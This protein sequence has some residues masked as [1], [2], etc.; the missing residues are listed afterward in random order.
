MQTRFTKIFN[1]RYPIMLGGMVWLGRSQLAAAVS[2]AG[3][4]GTIN[5]SNFRTGDAL[6]QEIRATK[7]L[8]DYPF[9]VNISLH[10]ARETLPTD[11]YIEAV[12]SEGV[13]AVETSGTR[14]PD[15]Y[16][17]ALKS[18]GVKII[19][20]VSSIR[21]ALKAEAGGVDAA[22]MVGL[23]GGGHVG[24]NDLTTLIKIPLAA[25]V[26]KVPVIAAGG[27]G[28]A[29]GLVAALAMGADGVVMGTRFMATEECLS[30]PKFKQR[31]IQASAEE[32][33]L[34]KRTINDSTRALSNQATMKVRLMEERGTTLDELW[35]II[36]GDNSRKVYLD[37]EIDH[38]VPSCGQVVGLIREVTSV[39]KLIDHMVKESDSIIQR[40]RGIVDTKGPSMKISRQ[41]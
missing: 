17:P 7:R 2:N 10:P 25:D 6:I 34:I 22:A 40:L 21:H 13:Q 19:H 4:L 18:A 24:A 11:E 9:A 36:S 27:I 20:K 35:P 39:A 33:V 30:H 8:T 14:S 41:G 3:G 31:L 23:E 32:A 1:I 5:S 28:D 29:R 16:V 15:E 38:G 37:G 26:L 12:I